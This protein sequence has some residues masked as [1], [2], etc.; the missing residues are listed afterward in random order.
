VNGKP[1][2]R[3]EAVLPMRELSYSWLNSATEVVQSGQPVRVVVL[4]QQPAPD[5]K[6]VVSLKRLEEDP[7][8]ETLDN[9]L[10]LNNQ[11]RGS[12]TMT[13]MQPAAAPAAAA[14]AKQQA[15]G[16]SRGTGGHEECRALGT[17]LWWLEGA[18]AKRDWDVRLGKS[19]LVGKQPDL[20]RSVPCC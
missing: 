2:P 18:A 14:A 7:L 13:E 17:C 6:V 5:A 4:F 9:V 12:L 19:M 10:P 8:K 11:A 20:D 16:G 15:A 3:A 1:C